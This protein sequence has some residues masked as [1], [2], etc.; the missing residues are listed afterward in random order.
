MDIQKTTEGQGTKVEARAPLHVSRFNLLTLQRF[1]ALPS[2]AFTLIELLIVISII[3]LLAGL[4]IPA[5]TGVKHTQIKKRA[6]AELS[7][8]RM[9][10]DSY[11][12]QLGYYPP[13]NHS[14]NA[15]TNAFINQLYYEL[16]GTSASNNNTI[17]YPLDGNASILAST[18]TNV[19]F[20]GGLMNCT[21]GL[22]SDD[23]S[24]R[25]QNFFRTSLKPGQY[26]GI[27]TNLYGS[28]TVYTF[29]ALGSY[30]PGPVMLPNSSATVGTRINPF[31]YNSSNPT[32]N[33]G[34]YDLWI[35]VTVGSQTNR[36]CNWS[37]TPF[38]VTNSN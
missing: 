5:A 27:S 24:I 33:P 2:S 25:A 22:G 1:N 10:I 3:A 30:L 14:P 29:T 36:I 17:F 23:N 12:I 4:L 35:D 26:L 20:V 19:F 37:T 31:R 38:V 9:A 8:V 34:T 28:P 6:T 21:R 7:E 13:D 32:N 15:S 18:V 11:K 16:I